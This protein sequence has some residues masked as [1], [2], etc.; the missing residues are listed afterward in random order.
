MTKQKGTD[1]STAI[2]WSSALVGMIRYSAAFL[3]SDLGKIT[4]LLS[5]V[6]TFLLGFSGFFMGI[7]GTLGTAYIF[8]GWR[9]KM[10]KAGDHWSNKFKALTFFVFAAL[11]CEVLIL[12]PFTMSRIRHNSI[13]NV[14]GHGDWWWATA[15]TV[16]PILLIGGVSMSNQIV[17]VATSEQTN[18][19]ANGSQ[20]GSLEDK[21]QENGSRKYSSLSATEK[22]YIINNDS[23]I[24]AEE[25][26]VTPR[27]IQKWRIRVQEEITQGKL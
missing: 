6:V 22:Y 27:A 19:P 2:I 17:T 18:E 8:D 25:L 12:V 1:Y 7:L 16:M 3:S 14:L 15:I 20:N 13:A 4:G 26:K 23:K 9:Q 5:E 10:P 24:V 11:A 21:N